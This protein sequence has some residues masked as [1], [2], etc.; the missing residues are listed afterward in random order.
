ML[1]TAQDTTDED[2]ETF[3]VT[4]SGVSSNAQLAAD[5]TATGTIEDD[6]TAPTISTVAVTST[7]V[8]DTDTYG[9]GETIEVSVTFDEA[10]T[11]TSD[12]DFVLSVAGAKRAPLVRGS[13]TATLVFGYTVAPGDADD[14][15]IWIGDQDR[16]LVGDRNGNP[17]SGTIASVATST[18]ADLTHAELGQL[19]DHKV[20]GSRSIVSV[21]VTSTPV[22]ETDTYGAGETIRFTVTFTAEVDVT[23]DPVLQFALGNS[24]NVREVD[25]AHE[26]G[27]GSKAL[28]FG[29]TVVSTDED[30]NGIFL[31]DEEDFDNPDGPVRLDS[32]DEI[33]FKGTSTD[34]PLYWEG[35]GTQSGHKVDGSRTTGNNPPSFTSLAAFDAAENQTAAG[36]VAAADSDAD[37]S[38]TGY[39]ITGGADQALFEIG[40][41]TGELTFKSAPNFED[42]QD[43]DTD[44]GHEV[45]VR[46][47]SGAGTRVMTADQTITV[48]VTDVNEKSAKPDKP[49]LAKV[50]GSSTSLTA[51]WTKPDLDGGPE[52]TGYVVQYRE[53]PDGPWH[54]SGHSGPGLTTTITGLTADTSYQVQVRTLNGEAL[55]DWSDASD[56]VKTN[57]AVTLPTLSVAD[58]SA[59]EGSTINF[60]L[61]L[62]AAASEI[63]T[64]ACTA[65]IESG[66][67][68]VAADLGA[69]TTGTVSVAAGTTSGVCA[70]LSAQDTTDEEDE[71]FTVTLSGVSSN[72]QLAA[73]PTATGTIEDDDTAPT[74]ST[75][76]VT[77]TP[78][79]DTDTYGAGETIEVSVTFDEAVNATSDTDFELN[80]SGDRS[81][82]LLRG[83][84]TATLVFGYT[85][86]SSDEDDNG[87]WIGDQDRTLVGARRLMAQSGTITSV[88]SST[89]ADLTHSALGTDS[90]HKVDGSRSIVSVAVTSTPVLETDTYGAG[91]TIR[92]TVTFSAA[93]NIGGSPVFRFSLGNLGV[94]L[95]VDAAY[96]SGAGSAALVFGYTVVSS[97]E[98]DDGIWIGHQGQTLVGTHQTGTITIVAT[99]EAA[100]I[101]HAALGVQTGHKVDGSRTTGNNPP[102]FTSSANLSVEENKRSAATAVVV[103]VDSDADDG[104]TG[105]A[106]TGGADN[107]FFSV[108]TSLGELQFD[109]APNFEDPKDGGTDNT[110]VV[111]VQATSGT[112]TREMTA[113]QTITVT[114]T[115]A[116][117]KSAKPDKPAL[118][119]VTGSTTSLTASWTKPDP[120]GGPEITGYALEYREGT[121]G[122]W[123]NFAHSGT[124]LTTTVTGLTADTSY[125]VQ[126][127]AKNGET[128]SDWSDASDAVKT[129]AETDTPTTCTLQTNDVWCGVVTVGAETNTGGATT[130]HGF[131]SITGNS[132]GTLTDNS[133]DQRFTYGTQ[134]YLVNRVVAGAGTFAGELN[135]R[136]RRSAPE[137]FLLDDDHV[138]KLALHVDGSSNPFAF[139]VATSSTSVGYIWRNSGLDWSSATTVTVRLR[140]LP[141]A[142]T[143]FEAAVG[144]AQVPLTWAAPASGANIT[145]HEFRY[146]TGGSYPETWTPIAASAPGGANEASFTVAGLTNEIAHT[147]ELR[148]ANDSGGSEAVE[149][150][151]VT[152]TPG[153]CDR[154]QKIQDVILAELTGVT[155]CAAVTVA[156]L[157]SITKFGVTDFAL[158]Q[159]GI[160]SL[161]AGDFAGLTGL[162]KLNLNNNQ[163]TSLP[164]GIFSGLTAIQEI[165]LNNNQLTSLAEG[166]FAGLANLRGIEV[167]GNKLP[168]LPAGL[169]TGLMLETVG[170]GG[171]E[172]TAL[173]A[174]LFT[175]VTT[176]KD[177][178]LSTSKLSSL[179]AGVFHGLTALTDL[180]LNDGELTSL[181]AGVFDGLTA[182]ERLN[183]RNCELTSLPGTVFSGLTALQSLRLDQNELTQTG[184]PAGLFSGLSALDTLYL[185]ENELESLPDGL[186]SGLTALGLL[187][188]AGNDEDPLPLTVTVEKVGT[189]QARA[190]VPV[191]APFA[192]EFT[193]VVANGSLPAS[194][195]KLAVAAG[196]VEG[197]AV[198]VTRTSGTTE[199]VTVDI[200]LTTQPSLPQNHSGYEFV[201]ATSGLPKEILS[202]DSNNAPVFDPATAER[203][204]PENSAAGTDVGDPIPEAADEDTGDTLDYSLEGDDAR[205]FDFDAS[206]RQIT[207]KANVTYNYEAA[208]NEY[209]VNV[210]ADDGRD[211]ATLAVTIRLTDVAERPAKPEKPTLS[212]ISGSSTSLMASWVKPGR[213]GGPD[214]TGYG[215]QYREGDA[216]WTDFAH[217]G[218]GV[219]TTITELTAGASYQVRVRAE[220]GELDSAWSDPS[221]AAV[222]NPAAGVLPRIT[223]VRVTSVPE[224]ERDT[225]GRGETIRFTVSFS[226]PVEVTGSPHLT[227]SLGNRNATRKVDAPYESGS[228]TAALVFGYVVREGDEDEN[229]I[230]LVDGDALGRAGPVALDAGETITALGAAWPRTSPRRSGGPSATTR[231]TARAPWRAMPRR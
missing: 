157:A 104:I 178:G 7:P 209:E 181:D 8:L 201:K 195:T 190:E 127:R 27:S 220:N 198:T 76:A 43:S 41:S 13:G 224:L 67:T 90:D 136:V 101:E 85:V 45:T 156:N 175:C 113:T 4:L 160:T 28:V 226:A 49:T 141:D 118:A 182:L 167:H 71:T 48:T 130:G 56:A 89:A 92:F 96:E 189:D 42:P 120:D 207:T 200:D 98:D 174:G 119:K 94:G 124:G 95:Q 47:T 173:P 116:D 230:F 165:N 61:T 193:P 93:V 204:V 164:A 169:F 203:E 70:F 99:S 110:Y 60:P 183:L 78:V 86:V 227:F 87:I 21:A 2:D 179:D 199:P 10:V 128:D 103:A 228:G 214:I 77:S 187:D 66:D 100:G 22:L 23:G 64:A 62:S 125:Q 107:S 180:R 216:A 14:N 159:Q 123:T 31:R 20:D 134:T 46:A 19:S 186:L 68:A 154:T 142:P 105:Y 97:D 206:T 155:D 37:D 229:G 146:K 121:T 145:R 133:G 153:I 44:N 26:S 158:F 91:E 172:F 79:L 112:G 18:A 11:A 81:A 184:L 223:A 171:N 219:S 147:F 170:L 215:V 151:P 115:D 177:I 50:T 188:L 52:I 69:T 6:D 117:E 210:K 194:D 59:T 196:S 58:A 212:P 135:F 163:L 12:T 185:N 137:G 176:L 144:D 5:P 75:V 213:N 122:T 217:S 221:D 225:Y 140:E 106:I 88:A 32:N 3:T 24:G 231:W 222:P 197:T 35:R 73:D 80:V 138:A 218:T 16:T 83:S 34:V 9:A 17:Q 211:S 192:V 51:T 139:K 168:A 202:D 63:V 54:N 25:A 74:I 205:F 150:G 1:D 40:A 33:E 36:T 162:T 111:T 149:D 126:V 30:D 38:V 84:G 65:S 15:G 39:A 108:V 143:G 82:P 166:T 53:A 29:Y 152:P 131:S 132:F 191:G 161:Q 57:A 109:N 102:V 208:K 148:A 114:V 55:S 72:A 129:N